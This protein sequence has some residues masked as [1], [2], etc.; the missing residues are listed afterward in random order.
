MVPI[1]DGVSPSRVGDTEE[2]WYHIAITTQPPLHGGLK[3]LLTQ[4]SLAPI[5][6][7]YDVSNSVYGVEIASKFLTIHTRLP[8]IDG[9]SGTSKGQR[10]SVPSS[11]S[12]QGDGANL[13]TIM[14]PVVHSFS[15]GPLPISHLSYDEWYRR[16]VLV[17][18]T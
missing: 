15:R 18:G 4:H 9:L 3:T 5:S 17:G 10:I 1:L 2:D 13:L 16:S 14:F 8:I 11:L 6:T 7:P 12:V